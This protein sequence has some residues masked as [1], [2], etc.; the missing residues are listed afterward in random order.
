MISFI[1]ITHIFFLNAFFILYFFP[2]YLFDE[3]SFLALFT[4]FDSLIFGLFLKYIL[5]TV[6]IIHCVIPR[7]HLSVYILE[8]YTIYIIHATHSTCMLYCIQ[9]NM[10]YTLYMGHI[11][12]VCC[13][14]YNTIY[15]IHYTM[16]N[17]CMSTVLFSH[18]VQYTL[19][20]I[21]YCTVYAV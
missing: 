11:V 12:R 14:V 2:F 13:I 19:Y 8:S 7:T 16:N 21:L 1:L 9:Y 17:F 20:S 10:Q 3:D 15:N 5:Y 4:I 18:C 6:Y